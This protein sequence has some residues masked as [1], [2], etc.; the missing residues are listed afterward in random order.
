MARVGGEDGP[1]SSA[2]EMSGLRAV[3]DLGVERE[4]RAPRPLVL[5]FRRRCGWCGVQL[6]AWQVNLCRGCREVA[7]GDAGL[8]LRSGGPRWR[9][10]ER[11]EGDPDRW[12]W[13]KA[14]LTTVSHLRRALFTI[15]HGYRP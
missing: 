9:Q 2:E 12:R 8:Y 7:F 14:L 3:P 5:A 13:P 6:R 4:R 15:L 1:Q 10:M 11:W